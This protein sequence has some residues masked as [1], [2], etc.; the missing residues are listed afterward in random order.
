M[1]ERN[2]SAPYW[3][4]LG[5][6]IILPVL[7]CLC[8]PDDQPS[9]PEV[10]E[11]VG[12]RHIRAEG[13]AVALG[14]NQSLASE[15]ERP[16]T[17]CRMGHD[18]WIDTTEVTFGDYQAV[19]GGLPPGCDTAGGGV[20]DRPA[21]FVSWYDAALYCNE[22][23]KR[24]RL[25]TV[26]RYASVSLLPDGRVAYLAGLNQALEVE[27]YR[28]PTESEW[29]FAAGGGLD[30]EF[31][32][33]SDSAS[34]DSHAWYNAN[35]SDMTHTVAELLPNEYG[36]YDLSGNVLEWTNDRK[37]VLPGD[38]VT[39]FCG[40]GWT[41]GDL[42]TVKGGAYVHSVDALRI[43]CRSDEYET[44]SATSSRYIGFRCVLGVIRTPLYTTASGS[45]DSLNVVI[46]SCPDLSS[47]KSVGRVTLAFVNR[48]ADV[49]TLCVLAYSSGQWRLREFTDIRSAHL[50]TVSP[51]GNWVAYCTRGEGLRNG[52]AVMVRGLLPDD[53]THTTV[54]DTPAF[55]P[56]W[57][58]DPVT[59][60]TFLVYTNSTVLND[61]P[62]WSSTSTMR[63]R[64]S[65]ADATGPPEVVCTEG[66]FH[67][68][69]SGGGRYLATGLPWLRMRDRSVGESRT[70]FYG[71]LNG[72]DVGD[73]SQVCNVSI[74]PAPSLDDRVLF[75]DFGFNGVS[76]LVGSA[77]GVHEYLFIGTFGGDVVRWYHAP[78]GYG[79]WGHPEWSNVTR[80]AVAG[81]ENGGLHPSLFMVDL[82]G[83][84]AVEL[85][86]GHD[87]LHPYLWID[88]ASAGAGAVPDS[89][90]QYDTPSLSS[91]QAIFAR[92]MKGFWPRSDSVEV[93]VLGSSRP[94][95]GIDC[96]YF[97]SYRGYNLAVN[98]SGPC[99][100]MRIA[101]EYGVTACP[102]LK[103][104]VM[105]LPI[106]MMNNP[107][108]DLFVWEGSISQSAGYQYDR[109]HGFWATGLP[110]GFMTSLAASPLS[111]AFGTVVDS[112]GA[113]Q[114]PLHGVG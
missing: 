112:L 42:L 35:A 99:V 96:S 54:A 92:K 91:C 80:F 76:S 63:V 70:L 15:D 34:A 104:V 100:A 106:E 18:F 94:S 4:L 3:S 27:G 105:D 60:D 16:V 82:E 79:A 7:V 59:S 72:K 86:R 111:V 84:A 75:L 53:S 13:C 43:A 25:D 113:L 95:D 32:W 24:D 29:V 51:D 31:P 12:M 38:T 36:L 93:L 17:V 114:V 108:E 83:G 102:R 109:N 37:A 74:S 44:T 9:S 107:Y 33:G 39:E 47:Q 69:L 81:G 20:P 41:D 73:T 64:M 61:D 89:A 88:P 101:R 26:Y 66:S 5:P 30:R 103:A 90:G 71:P 56:R 40:A 78:D 52:S 10:F 68:G 50:P 98:G 6:V 48:T 46:P 87:L 2:H 23:S 55:C 19:T 97:D 85:V 77:Y 62:L 1:R 57:W 110:E 28:L 14:S 45:V 8:S 49:R 22:R 11:P 58:V 65:G 67:G 21:V